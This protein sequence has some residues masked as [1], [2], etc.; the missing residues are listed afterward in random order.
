MRAQEEMMAHECRTK[1][2]RARK[3]D[4]AA[5]SS[6]PFLKA[7]TSLATASDRSDDGEVGAAFYSCFN[8]RLQRRANCRYDIAHMAESWMFSFWKLFV[9]ICRQK[10]KKNMQMCA[11]L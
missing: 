1:G 9:S 2:I 6:A 10:S 8:V 7:D 3:C 5:V 4:A 11:G